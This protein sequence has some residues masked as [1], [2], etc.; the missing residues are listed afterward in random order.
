MVMISMPYVM[1]NIY[2]GKEMHHIKKSA[3]TV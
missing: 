2:M 3:K 1:R